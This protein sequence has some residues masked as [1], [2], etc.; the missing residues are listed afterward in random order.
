MRNIPKF[1]PSL[2][3]AFSSDLLAFSEQHQIRGYEVCPK[4]RA[5]IVT[6][7]NILQE[8]AGNHA[9]GMWGRTDTGFASLPNMKDVLFV[10]TRLQIRMHTYPKWGD[11]V[12]VQTH[13]TE[14][15]RLAARRDWQITDPLTGEVLGCATSTW[16]TI[17]MATRK[18]SKLP[19]DVRKR[20]MRLSSPTRE[21][22]LPVDETRMK[23]PDMQLP[24]EVEGE[25]QVARRSDM[26]MN[27]HINNVTFLA[28]SLEAV[29][30][31]IYSSHSLYEVE[32][33]FKAECTAGQSV[34]SHANSLPSP[35]S[36]NG[37]GNGNGNGHSANKQFVHSV[38]RCET[39]NGSTELVR[40]RTTWRPE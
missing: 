36:S 37:N 10:M 35:P 19:D 34:E 33:D 26:D 12:H 14:E 13:F 31:E 2:P 3:A 5:T 38:R 21:C 18:L 29:P 9:V 11:I 8:A 7:S 20:F 25:V 24:A 39:G 32:I 16:V 40:A 17:N 28:W 22:V 23:L 27:G 4:Q 6:I 1:S 15:G 30:E